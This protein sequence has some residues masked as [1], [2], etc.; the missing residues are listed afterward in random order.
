[1]S[2]FYRTLFHRQLLAES[3]TESEQLSLPK[4]LSETGLDFVCGIYSPF[5]KDS[6]KQ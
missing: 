3:G 5:P 6:G 4:G 1:M 2:L